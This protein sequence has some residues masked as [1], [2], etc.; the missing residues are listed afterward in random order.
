MPENKPK[1]GPEHYEAGDIIIQQGDEPEKFY[2]ITRG[3]VEVIYEPP[4]GLDTVIAQMGPGDYFGEVGMLWRSRRM[5]TIRAHTAVELM[6][7]DYQTFMS[8]MASV[9]EVADEIDATIE[10]RLLT[11]HQSPQP[12]LNDTALKAASL[13]A[14][15]TN[16][17]TAVDT[18]AQFQAGEII[19]RQGDIA[20]KFYV[21]TEGFV[22][23]SH[24]LADG[25]EKTIDHLTPG[26]YFGEIGLLEGSRRIASV[27]ALTNVKLVAFER[28]VFKNWMRKSPGS[29]EELSREATRRR[30]DTGQLTLNN[31]ADNQE[32]PK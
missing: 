15:V 12:L 7:M 14:D 28:E 26:D 27:T 18:P 1:F 6:T 20:D 31:H 11:S 29:Q 22:T 5:A 3:Q 10:E 24:T 23:V 19:I 2:I 25:E 13:A 9:P 8:W 32:A 17:P 21:I 16:H 30:N 4:D